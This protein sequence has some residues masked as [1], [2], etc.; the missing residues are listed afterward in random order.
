MIGPIEN[1][2]N[3][4]SEA[5]SK[6][7][8]LGVK[9]DALRQLTTAKT[10]GIRLAEVFELAND[11][12]QNTLR[13]APKVTKKDISH[14][15]TLLT[16][17]QL[18]YQRYLK[19]TNT[20]VRTMMKGLARYTP[21]FLKEYLPTC[22]SNRMEEKEKKTLREYNL[23][24]N[25]LTNQISLLDEE[26]SEEM[27]EDPETQRLFMESLSTLNFPGCPTSASSPKELET[28]K[29]KVIEKKKLNACNWDALNRYLRLLNNFQEQ[30]LTP[31]TFRK[32]LQAI[33]TAVQGWGELVESDQKKVD[34]L[35]CAPQT[36]TAL[37][38]QDLLTALMLGNDENVR[39]ILAQTIWK[40]SFDEALAQHG[41]IVFGAHKLYGSTVLKMVNEE[42]KPVKEATLKNYRGQ[43]KIT[44]SSIE[45]LSEIDELLSFLKNN[46]TCRPNS[47]VINIKDHKPITGEF[48]LLL[49]RL[50]VRV[51]E[52]YVN[53]LH[54]IDFN[55]LALTREEEDCFVQKLDAYAFP[56]LKKIVLSDRPKNDWA[57]SR[58]SILLG[59][60]PSLELLQ[61]CYQQCSAYQS[62]TLPKALI[63]MKELDAQHFTLDQISHLLTEC[64]YLTHLNF[65]GLPLTDM[66]LSNWLEKIN[67]TKIESL[68]LEHCQQLTT[69]ILVSLAKLPCLSTLLLPELPKGTLPLTDLPKSDNPFKIKLLY[70]RTKTTQSIASSLYTGPHIWASIFQIPLARLG[71]QSVFPNS[72]QLIT[73][74]NVAYWLHKSDYTYL[75]PQEGILVVQAD[76]NARLNDDNIVEWMQKFPKAISLSLY[77]CP[78]VTHRGIVN[79][80]ISSPQL[81]TLDLTGCSGVTEELLTGQ[82]HLPLLKQ[83]KTLNVTSTGIT[84]EQ[85]KTSGKEGLNLIFENARLKITD[86]DLPD[87]QAF[88]RMLSERSLV[89]LKYIDLEGCEKLSNAMLGML[90]DRFN[91]AQL[92]KTPDGMIVN[93]Q[94]LNAAV[95]NI[96][97]CSQISE[98]AFIATS[99][100]KAEEKDES[101]IE[102]QRSLKIDLKLLESLDRIVMGGTRLPK[103]I[104]DKYPQVTFQENDAIITIPIDPQLQLQECIAYHEIKDLSYLD[105]E[106]KIELRKLGGRYLH[107]RTVVELFCEDHTATKEVL[108]HAVDIQ[109][110]DFSDFMLCFMT[111]ELYPKQKAEPKSFHTH[112][113]VLSAQS[114]VFLNDLRPGGAMHKVSGLDILN[115]HA[116]PKAATA[117]MDVVYGRL[118]INQLDWETAA[119]VAEIIGPRCF[120]FLSVYYKELLKHIHGQFDLQSAHDMLMTAKALE[121]EE[122][123]NEYEDTLLLFLQNLETSDLANFQTIAN[124]ATGHGLKRLRAQVEKMERAKTEALI[125][126]ELIGQHFNDDALALAMFGGYVDA[127]RGRNNGR[128]LGGP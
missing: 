63:S 85:V 24:K 111:E 34:D 95:I 79:L 98:E 4:F 125:Q 17:G 11:Q 113:D 103:S 42:S 105:D 56:N 122:G 26:E 14:L 107:N 69:N 70:T 28:E 20:W 120:K 128:R 72:Q 2:H 13:K 23:F 82:G 89:K 73:P 27:D 84:Y 67:S 117:F 7:T 62:I 32:V 104:R 119:H 5:I 126:E 100:K 48:I 102:E 86:K 6:Q 97:D 39:A 58:F 88:E 45:S 112:R 15:K 8:Y 30:P 46:S 74:K 65:S 1:L 35:D 54:E 3:L 64:L 43:I 57:P 114:L 90:L 68:T 29:A 108:R 75:T 52:V 51:A 37:K 47:I 40:D 80:L 12:I 22:F 10:K 106:K 109:S 87:D 94:R 116:T 76:F 36:L 127:R 92:I 49:D 121:D 115:V 78:H 21:K 59:H 66:Q 123:R 53:G 33:V 55:A 16:D 41:H 93:P 91:A 60:C 118:S 81:R 9:D 31:S 25:H 83:L 18:I 99:P 50:K 124:L 44:I 77:D 96:K 71:V 61:Q 19:S 110:P 101:T 38:N